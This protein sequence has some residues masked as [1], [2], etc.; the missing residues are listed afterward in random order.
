MARGGGIPFYGIPARPTLF[1][2]CILATTSS[3]ASP[4]PFS[5]YLQRESALTHVSMPGP[6]FSVPSPEKFSYS[7]VST[8]NTYTRFLKQATADMVNRDA[9]AGTKPQLLGADI[10]FL[11]VPNPKHPKHP[12]NLMPSVVAKWKQHIHQL[13]GH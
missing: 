8:A 9:T 12:K 11:A 2:L 10:G 6:G 5:R 3:H 7:K 1:V 4:T 13:D